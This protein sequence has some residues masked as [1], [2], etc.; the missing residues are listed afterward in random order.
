M[1]LVLAM[2]DDR[3]SPRFDV[4]PKMSVYKIEGKKIV[5]NKDIYCEEWSE[6]ERVQRLKDLRVDIL[7]CGAIT[8]NLCEILLNNGTRII[9]W[10]NG[11]ADDFLK[12]FF[13]SPTKSKMIRPRTTPLLSRSKNNS[14]SFVK[15]SDKYLENKRGKVRT[16][17]HNK[18][19]PAK[20]SSKERR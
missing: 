2:F 9:P 17:K 10:V 6:M 13:K 16:K 7:V 1:K 11:N 20:L 12:K 14:T 19:S 15:G 3:I 4:A 8:N 18:G 5:H